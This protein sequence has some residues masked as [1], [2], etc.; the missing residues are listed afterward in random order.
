MTDSVYKV[1][2]PWVKFPAVKPKP[3]KNKLDINRVDS[4]Q[5]AIL[6][7]NQLKLAGRI[8]RYRDRLGGFVKTEQ[9]KEV[10]GLSEKLYQRLILNVFITADFKPKRLNIL[11]LDFKALISHPYID[12]NLAK[13]LIRF[14]EHCGEN[15]NYESLSALIALEGVDLQRLKN[16]LEFKRD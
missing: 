1:L 5:L 16:Y 8:I 4:V 12:Y 15:C 9:L 6:I 13:L 11:T 3:Q 14:R 10:Y 7:H 2:Q